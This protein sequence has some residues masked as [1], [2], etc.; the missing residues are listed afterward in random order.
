[1]EQTPLMATCAFGSA[2]VARV[3]LK[4]GAN[5][6]LCNKVRDLEHVHTL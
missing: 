6:D 1:M 5:V 2:D 4:H 3:L